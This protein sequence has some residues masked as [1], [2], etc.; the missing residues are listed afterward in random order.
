MWGVSN[1]LVSFDS[2]LFGSCL[3][4]SIN[5]L[6][7]LAIL[8]RVIL[9]R[10]NVFSGGFILSKVYSSVKVSNIL[11]KLLKVHALPFQTAVSHPPLLAQPAW[12]VRVNS[13]QRTGWSRKFPPH[14]SPG[15]LRVFYL[16][17]IGTV[18]CSWG[19]SSLQTGRLPCQHRATKT[20]FTFIQSALHLLMRSVVVSSQ[21]DCSH[22]SAIIWTQP[23]QVWRLC[24]R[25]GP[26]G[27]FLLL[28]GRTMQVIRNKL[29]A[30]IGEA[31]CAC[32]LM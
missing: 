20:A 17:P 29:N 12:C 24:R 1:Q 23:A 13:N 16:S 8:S 22:G 4:E 25:D 31:G 6:L 15:P 26:H 9:P 11:H 27:A 14:T 32:F 3:N 21:T 7:H 5:F 10:W 18:K 28:C 30:L 2:V 19:K